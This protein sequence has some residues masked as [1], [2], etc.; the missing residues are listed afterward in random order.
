MPGRSYIGTTGYR[1]GMNGK[2]KDDE[3]VGSGNSYDFGARIYN[4]RLGRWLSVD[5]LNAKQ[6]F[7]SPYVGFNDNPIYFVDPDGNVVIPAD[8]KTKEAFDARLATIFTGELK[9]YAD[10]LKYGVVGTYKGDNGA[11]IEV[12]G[13]IFVPTEKVKTVEDLTDLIKTTA[14][15]G[16]SNKDANKQKA[17]AV[18]YAT[19]IGNADSGIIQ[20]Q[21]SGTESLGIGI[22]IT[23][24]LGAERERACRINKNENTLKAY[25]GGDGVNH[26]DVM[27]YENQVEVK[28]GLGEIKVNYATDKATPQTLDKAIGD[29]T[30]LNGE[31]SNI[32]ITDEKTGEKIFLNGSGEIL[33][34]PAPK[35]K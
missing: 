7:V 8:S 22:P 34:Q 24:G 20:S 12:K 15:S 13:Y 23:N 6:P 4:P 21:E 18:A 16:I 5:P 32:K 35:K 28:L 2:E 27:G 17:L 11:T 1:Y 26:H 3:I 10:N 14:L 30:I 9:Q 19:A 31:R 33:T 25:T 29:F